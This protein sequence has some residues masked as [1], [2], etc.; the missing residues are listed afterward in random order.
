M[1]SS[2][3]T[4]CAD[5]GE[6]RLLGELLAGGLGHAEV[7]HLGHRFAVVQCDQNVGRLQI[8]VDDPFLMGMLHRLA[9]RHEQ[10]Q[11]FL[12]R[13]SVPDRSTW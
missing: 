2:V 3:P 8:A 6:Q 10:F 13:E 1:Y 5:F 9:N 11:A 4:T 12:R 7:D